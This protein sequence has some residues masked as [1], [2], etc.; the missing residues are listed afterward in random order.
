MD[1]KICLVIS[2]VH[3]GGIEADILKYLEFINKTDNITVLVRSDKREGDFLGNFENSG[4]ALKFMSLGYL[5][6]FKFY[7]FYKFYKN[8]KFH[9]VCDFNANFAALSIFAAYLAGIKNRITFYKQGQ[10]LFKKSALK[11]LISKFFNRIVYKYSTIILSNSHA[12]IAYFFPY[13]KKSDNRFDVIYGGIE[14]NDFEI[15]E[16]KA[17][18]RKMKGIPEDKYIIGHVGRFTEAKNHKVILDVCKQISKEYNDIHFL[19]RGSDTE[20]LKPRIEE[21]G[22]SENITLLGYQKD[23]PRVLKSFDLFFF[24]S[25]TEGQPNA[26]LE[27]MFTGL[28]FVASNIEPIKE[29]VPKEF[30]KYLSNPNDVDSFVKSILE[31][32]EEKNQTNNLKEYALLN[33]SAKKNLNHF[34]NTLIK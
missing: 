30:H 9:T 8:S 16:S 4:A 19:L 28:P 1:K 6:P 18:I 27:A 7:E 25:L 20:N 22:I 21:L 2:S 15:S 31:L 24:P 10:D 34:H 13:R 12:A 3:S 32:K 17:E 11:S 5:N 23:I 29:C 26:L 14:P 33:F